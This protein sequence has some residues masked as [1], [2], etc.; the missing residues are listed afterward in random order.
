[1]SY[2]AII[3][4][5]EIF[6]KR[7][8]GEKVAY[9]E[10]RKKDQ[11]FS[12]ILQ[13]E[14]EVE[15]STFGD[16]WRIIMRELD[17]MDRAFKGALMRHPLKLWWAESKKKP[18]SFKGKKD[19]RFL[20]VYWHAQVHSDEEFD[21]DACFGGWGRWSGPEKTEGGI[22]IDFLPFS[23]LLDI[24]FKVE[25]DLQVWAMRDKKPRFQNKLKL[26]VYDVIHAI[27][28][29]ISFHGSPER[30]AARGK[31]LAGRM[32]GVKKEIEKEGQGGEESQ[33]EGA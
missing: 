9:E 5:G 14:L 33:E 2:T 30:A 32:K 20:R 26:T 1:M 29:E 21:L 16:I 11:T 19:V 28:W 7:W 25:T 6:I 23:S 4:K 17:F 13:L 18:K 27:L 10:K 22:G 12:D 15:D 3:R 31:E 8:N 24:P